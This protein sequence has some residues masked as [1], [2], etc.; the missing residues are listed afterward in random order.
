MIS[1]RNEHTDK[2]RCNGSESNGYP[3][4]MDIKTWLGLEKVSL[5]A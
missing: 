1:L 4:I 2:P 5:V 3:P